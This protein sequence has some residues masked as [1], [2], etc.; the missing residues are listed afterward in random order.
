MNSPTGK[1]FEISTINTKANSN[2]FDG[3]EVYRIFS[4]LEQSINR[5]HNSRVY[6]NKVLIKLFRDDSI[7]YKDKVKPVN[8]MK[9]KLQKLLS[10]KGFI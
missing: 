9:Q 2:V 8:K 3:K 7:N 10:K 1:K 4:L 6:G 5:K